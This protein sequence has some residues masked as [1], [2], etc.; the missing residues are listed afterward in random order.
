MKITVRELIASRASLA[1]INN[2]VLDMKTS[3]ALSEN[4]TKLKEVQD[5]FGKRREVIFGEYETTQETWQ[6]LPP[7]KVE[8]LDA[9]LEA[10][11]DEEI[12]VKLYYIDPHVLEKKSILSA[13]D[14]NVLEWVFDA[15]KLERLKRN[16]LGATDA[17]R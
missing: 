12:E 2:A 14:F 1:K 13:E 3:L 11:L 17:K 7:E 5:N 9:E 10:L 4:L 15:R 6:E 8:A 16:M